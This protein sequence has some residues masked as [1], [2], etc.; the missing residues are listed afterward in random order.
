M[1]LGESHMKCML[2]ILIYTSLIGLVVSCSSSG[3]STNSDEPQY[4]SSTGTIYNFDGSHLTSN[5]GTSLIVETV[6]SE[7]NT[8]C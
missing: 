6:N 5:R 3:G 2:H 8:R 1:I 7:G 4:Q